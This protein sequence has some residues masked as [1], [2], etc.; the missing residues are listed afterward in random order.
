MNVNSDGE[1]NAVQSSEVNREAGGPVAERDGLVEERRTGLNRTKS[2]LMDSDSA[3]PVEPEVEREELVQQGGG[4]E[5]RE[6]VIRDTAGEEHRETRSRDLAGSQW[7]WLSK[8]SSI[9]W[10]IIGVIEV[11]IGLRIILRAMDANPAN[12]FANFVYT[13][14]APL[15][16]PFFGLTGSPAAGG[17]VLE[18]SS[19]VAM[20]VYF[21]IGWLIVSVIWLAERPLTHSASRYDRYRI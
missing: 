13:V 5:R 10:L 4:F 11:L 1:T 19:F 9:V 3:R 6:S 16:A 15:L 14:T 20:I 7:W 17:A 18:V 12:P 2:V 8:L 21:L